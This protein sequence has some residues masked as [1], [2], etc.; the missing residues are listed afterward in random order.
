MPLDPPHWADLQGC[1]GAASPP[2]GS[3]R[4]GTCTSAPPGGGT[5]RQC[6]GSSAG[7][8]SDLEPPAWAETGPCVNATVWTF[9]KEALVGSYTCAFFVAL[10]SQQTKLLEVRTSLGR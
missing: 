1:P 2:Q 9:P 3:A 10:P 5:W 8:C 4:E 7:L 6:V